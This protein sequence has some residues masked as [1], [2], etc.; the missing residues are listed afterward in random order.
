MPF[1]WLL[2][3]QEEKIE[4]KGK[5]LEFQAILLRYAGSSS[6]AGRCGKV[7]YGNMTIR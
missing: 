4:E 6:V 2:P 3:G 1:N 7:C 5:I